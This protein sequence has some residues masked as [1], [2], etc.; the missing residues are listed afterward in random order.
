[1]NTVG[2][3]ITTGLIGGAALSSSADATAQ[4]KKPGLKPET[5]NEVRLTD[6]EVQELKGNGPDLTRLLA[7]KTEKFDPLK[8]AARSAES[9][10]KKISYSTTEP[11]KQA[12]NVEE[13]Q[14]RRDIYEQYGYIIPADLK[15][16]FV[17]N[18]DEKLSNRGLRNLLYGISLLEAAEHNPKVGKPGEIINDQ[19]IRSLI[20][21][22]DINNSASIVY[23]VAKASKVGVD[24]KPLPNSVLQND[25][26]S[27]MREH[28]ISIALD[29]RLVTTNR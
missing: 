2:K 15:K 4:E 24:G 1:M 22:T 25:L 7:A 5:T 6:A 11:D 14:Q 3:F 16:K 26:A 20:L 29:P 21:N 12:L 27:F 28:K 13:L 9:S 8:L 18:A 17:T 19:Q 23:S 10:T